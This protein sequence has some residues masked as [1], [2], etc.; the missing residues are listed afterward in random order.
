MIN[1]LMINQIKIEKGG[2]NDYQGEGKQKQLRL[3][4]HVYREQMKKNKNRRKK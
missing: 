2:E 3:K 1:Y 4:P